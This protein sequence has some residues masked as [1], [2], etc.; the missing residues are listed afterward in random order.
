MMNF[1]LENLSEIIDDVLREFCVTYPIPNFDNKE[2]LEHLRSVLEQFGADTLTDE[3][4]M[5]AIN[6]APKKFTL[7]A[8]KRMGA[9]SKTT[10]NKNSAA[11]QA[12]KLNLIGKGGISYGPKGND[13]ITHINK[14]GKLVK[15]E[16]RQRGKDGKTAT[17][18]PQKKV[19]TTK[20][21]KPV[22]KPAAKPIA[23]PQSIQPTP[24]D[25]SN[26]KAPKS[27]KDAFMATTK[28]KGD[29]KEIELQK[30]IQNAFKAIDK[31]AS[32]AKGKANVISLETAEGS[33][34][35]IDIP[36]KEIKIAIKNLMNGNPLSAT[37]KKI[38][39]VTTKIVTNP[40]NG[41]V[42]LYFA[43]KIAGRHPQQG[44]QSVELA[45][46]NVEMGDALRAYALKNKLNVGKSSEGA[47]GKKVL[48]PLKMATSINPKQ[49]VEKIKIEKN[50]EGITVAGVPVKYK[51]EP[52]EAK[53]VEYFGKKG[54]NPK[55]AAQKANIMLKQIKAWNGK[56]DDIFN[57][58]KE[59]NG[60][61]DFNNFG[62]VNSPEERKKVRTNLAKGIKLSFLEE[63]K[64]YQQTFGTEDLANKPENKEVFNTLDKLVKINQNADL[65]KD[66]KA[67]NEYKKEL[68]NLILNLANSADFKDAVADF[69]EIK[70][71]LQFLAEGKKV[72]FPALENFQT[73]DII[74]IPD[75]KDWKESGAKSYEE[76]LANNFQLLNV[77]L[78]YV[79]GLSVK[80]KGGGGSANYNKILMTVYNNPETQKRLLG[81]QHMYALAYNGDQQNMNKKE[82]DAAEK[83]ID[84]FFKWAISSKLISKEEATKIKAIG[85]Q[86]AANTIKA[87]TE[88]GNCGGKENQKQLHRAVGL[89]HIMMH[90]T[91]VINNKDMSY[92]RYGNF[93]EKLGIKG[94]KA[95][96]VQDDVA[97]GVIKPCYMSPHHNPGF[98]KIDKDGCIGM[99]PTNQNPSHIKSELPDLVKNFKDEA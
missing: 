36:V 95:S 52:N 37:D 83:E 80:Y 79:G 49:P 66:E 94:G 93:N 4:L 97:D 15:V 59:T 72:L 16:P 61:I 64:K 22:A 76:Y 56:I 46:K 45:L 21:Q 3:Q 88:A 44:Y 7:E 55:E 84:D 8:P 20:T 28:Q 17:A 14:D 50:K 10:Q 38:L 53:L 69:T 89:H 26:I 24:S 40:E 32:K 85:I 86:Q 47:V 41:D 19:T 31:T 27:F 48:T 91:A 2:Q 25:N 6:L 43:Q 34:K 65:E 87:N 74:I 99:T 13:L 58:G 73:A 96:S 67:R 98:N 12:H 63:L 75:D 30:K 68:D 62:D 9:V 42:K 77:S 71:G 35:F 11:D 90:A 92:T 5:E 82:V 60:I 29:K 33:G 39:K 57:A 18:A 51:K 1:N 81:I 23:K 70:A 78:E 54:F